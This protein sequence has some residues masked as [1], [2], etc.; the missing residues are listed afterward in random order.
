MIG[1]HPADSAPWLVTFFTDYAAAAKTEILVDLDD[2]V[3]RIR[4]TT[5]SAKGV[6]PCTTATCCRSRASRRI[7]TTR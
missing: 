5:G 3:R 1:A 4:I 2:L 6:L 7:T